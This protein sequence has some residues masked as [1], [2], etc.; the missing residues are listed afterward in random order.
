MYAFVN[1]RVSQLDPANQFLVW[2]M[3]GW[4]EA[5][6]QKQ[7]PGQAIGA[8]FA[9]QNMIAGLHPFLRMMAVLFLNLRDS[10]TCAIGDAQRGLLFEPGAASSSRATSRPSTSRTQ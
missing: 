3:R 2:A 7:C 8:A 5:V 10:R 6:G 9:R 4:V 1:R